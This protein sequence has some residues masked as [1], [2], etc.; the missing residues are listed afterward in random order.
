MGQS[1]STSGRRRRGSDRLVIWRISD[2]R[3]G[4]DNQSLGLAEALARQTRAELYTLAAMRPAAALV[5]WCLKRFPKPAITALPDLVIG[6]GHGTHLTL[7]AAKRA[8]GGRAVVLMR[9]SLPTKWFDLCLVPE[10][11]APPP[12]PRIVTTRGALTRIRPLPPRRSG[13]GLI[14]L[15]GPSR[16]FSWPEKGVLSQIDAIIAASPDTL[17]TLSSSPRTPKDT[18]QRVR[19]LNRP[20]LEVIAFQDTSPDWLGEQLANAA[21]VWITEDSVSMVYEALTSGAAVGLIELG[22]ARRSRIAEGLDRLANEAWVTRFS[23]WSA[24]QELSPP[25]SKLDEASR[26]AQLILERWPELSH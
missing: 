15:G 25:P 12:D 11:D 9:P 6:A 5:R 1:A 20:M 18:I 26:C 3:P 8:W 10:H 21:W 13:R 23:R 4:H 19:R 22:R 17:W 16:H 14:L 7:L 24:E 2:G